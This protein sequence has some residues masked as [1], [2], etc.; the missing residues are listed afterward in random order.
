VLVEAITHPIRFYF[1]DGQEVRLKP[2]HPVDLPQDRA[3][4]LLGK[5]GKKVR[6]VPSR[7]RP[8]GACTCCGG[9]RFWLSVQDA[10]I[11]GTCHPP[12][13]PSLVREWIGGES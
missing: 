7:P 12:A 3:R 13:N 11:C 5:V 2:G 6:V 1:A 4:R 9:T 10:L 8:A